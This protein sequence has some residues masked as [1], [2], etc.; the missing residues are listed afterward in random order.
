MEYLSSPV[1]RDTFALF[2]VIL[3]EFD[4]EKGYPF[5]RKALMEKAAYLLE[6]IV[7]TFDI[8]DRTDFLIEADETLK[9]LRSYL[10]MSYEL[11]IISEDD[12]LA[13]AEQT[14]SI[15]RQIG[16]WLKKEKLV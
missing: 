11:Q 5:F 13:F 6:V 12:Y 7:K 9:I 15:G 2:G 10:S 3:E 16:G 1:Y 8:A 4:V 14:D